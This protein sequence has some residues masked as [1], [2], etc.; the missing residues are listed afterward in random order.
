[1]R[2]GEDRSIDG[3]KQGEKRSRACTVQKRKRHPGKA[4]E[5]REGKKKIPIFVSMSL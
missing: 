2:K 3:E 4:A 5:K 1:M